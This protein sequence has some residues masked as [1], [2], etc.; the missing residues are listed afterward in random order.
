MLCFHVQHFVTMV[1]GNSHGFANLRGND[2]WLVLSISG[3]L[4]WPQ[5]ATQGRYTG[6]ESAQMKKNHI[7]H[8]HS[9]AQFN[10]S[11]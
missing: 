5:S 10:T 2:L 7:Q 9:S 8:L 1:W 11:F 4:V 3:L 6:G